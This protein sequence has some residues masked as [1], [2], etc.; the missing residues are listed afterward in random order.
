MDFSEF[1]PRN[2]IVNDG[3]YIPN[4][5]NSFPADPE[6]FLV[7]SEET[8][9]I[10]FD[11]NYPYLDHSFKSRLNTFLIYSGAFLVAFAANK[12]RYGLKIKGRSN[13]RRNR[14][15]F[16]NGAI[17]V[18]NH[19][20]RW[21]FLAILDA[22]RYRRMWVPVRAQ[23]LMGKDANLIRGIGGIPLADTI[24]GKKKFNQA[25][26]LLN[27]KK[28]WIHLFPESSRWDFYE[29][30][31]PFKSGAFAFAYRWNVPVIP[32]VFSYRKPTGIYRLFKTKHPLVT[33]TIGEP[34]MPDTSLP[35]KEACAAMRNQCH[36]VM[37]QMAGITQNMWPA[38]LE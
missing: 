5:L 11:E 21:D 20:Y 24:G 6:T 8:K 9:K 13:I 10:V 30:I 12:I 29:P 27:K 18:S 35:R 26:D 2:H 14:K 34:I 38:T 22:C 33:L 17:T 16:R 3:V 25:F 36:K 37:T 15:L 19:V 1:S 31:R 32:M 7:N 4:D 23:H 28:K